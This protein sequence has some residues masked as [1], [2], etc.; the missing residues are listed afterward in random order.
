[1]TTRH[2]IPTASPTSSMPSHLTA[3]TAIQQ[4]QQFLDHLPFTDKVFSQLGVLSQLG[5]DVDADG[6]EDAV[7][8]SPWTIGLAA[9]LLL[10]NGLFSVYL[11]LGLHKTL[12]IAAVRSDCCVKHCSIT[13][14]SQCINTSPK[15]Q[16]HAPSLCCTSQHQAQNVAVLVPCTDLHGTC[17]AYCVCKVVVAT[18]DSM[19]SVFSSMQDMA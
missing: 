14:A 1:M 7:Y 13:V 15:L 10:I 19:P 3:S 17:A 16:S 9:L 11:S 2:L 4:P 5:A 8:L 12:G 18:H 6:D